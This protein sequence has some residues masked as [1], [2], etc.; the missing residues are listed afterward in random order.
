MPRLFFLEFTVFSIFLVDL[1]HCVRDVVQ[2]Y[3]CFVVLESF[4]SVGNFSGWR[5]HGSK[6]KSLS[7]LLCYRLCDVSFYNHPMQLEEFEAQSLRALFASIFGA[8]T[9]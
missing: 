7:L 1:Q 9:P 3:R 8:V 5:N 6:L 2:P 4:D